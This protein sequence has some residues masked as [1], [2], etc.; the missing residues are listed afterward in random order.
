M[1]DLLKMLMSNLREYGK[2]FCIHEK[3]EYVYV[4][5]NNIQGDGRLFCFVRIKKFKFKLMF[6]NIDT[7]NMIIYIYIL[8]VN[9]YKVTIRS[10]YIYVWNITWNVT[11]SLFR[12]C[13]L[14]VPLFQRH[15][16]VRVVEQRHR[17]DPRS[18]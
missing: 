12:F 11:R 6:N 3:F 10:L 1:N 5:W 9:I 17:H 18:M 14:S 15:S 13:F 8:K 2:L 4:I 16:E 7:F